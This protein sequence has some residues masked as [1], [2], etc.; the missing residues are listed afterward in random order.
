MSILFSVIANKKNIIHKYA[1]CDG[2]FIDIVSEVLSKISF[3]NNKMT[4]IH[5]Q[6]LFNYVIE[7]E[8]VY[9]CVTDR[10]CQRSRAF[11]FLN[12]IKRSFTHKN[13]EDF[14]SIL[15]TEMS[16]YSQEY[17]HIKILDGE[18][19]EINKIDIESSESILGEKILLIKNEDNSLEFSTITSMGKPPQK[20]TVSIERKNLYTIIVIALI[21]IVLIM[22]ILGP[23]ILITII[24]VFLIDTVNRKNIKS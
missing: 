21:I 12:E 16:R 24:G 7:N 4:Y 19:D 13:T 10:T 6:Y 18:L 5:G 20:I 8:Y 22:Y 2:N 11:L 14:T 23:L 17:S 15:E 1:T 3:K 9:F